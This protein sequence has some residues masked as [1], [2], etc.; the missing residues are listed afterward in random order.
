MISDEPFPGYNLVIEGVEP[1]SAPER[2]R[3]T[4][5]TPSRQ[6]EYNRRA[7]RSKI[8]RDFS[9]QRLPPWMQIGFMETDSLNRISHYMGDRLLAVRDEEG[10][11]QMA[12]ADMEMGA[13]RFVDSG[14]LP[15]ISK[16]IRDSFEALNG[17]IRTL[18]GEEEPPGWPETLT[19]PHPQEIPIE[20]H[21]M[22]YE[23]ERSLTLYHVRQISD[24]LPEL[25]DWPNTTVETISIGDFDT[26]AQT[27]F[28]PLREGGAWDI[29]T[30]LKVPPDE[31]LSH[32]LLVRQGA[33]EYSLTSRQ[34]KGHPMSVLLD[35]HYPDVLL[36]YI[37]WMFVHRA[38]K[39]IAHIK[40]PLSSI[41]KTLIFEALG[42]ATGLVA[43]YAITDLTARSQFATFEADLGRHLIVVL[44]E[45]EKS[46]KDIRFGYLNEMTAARV[47]INKKFGDLYRTARTAT[48]VFVGG[49]WAKINMNDQGMDT[50]TPFA[51]D[52]PWGR[53]STDA[54]YDDDSAG[55][56][57]TSTYKHIEGCVTCHEAVFTE[58]MNRASRL[59]REMVEQGIDEVIARF[60]RHPQVQASLDRLTSDRPSDIGA[61]LCEE[62][63]IADGE[64][65]V[66]AHL[67]NAIK[68]ASA[69]LKKTVSPSDQD[70]SRMMYTFFDSQRTRKSINR[71]QQWVWPNVKWVKE[72]IYE[73]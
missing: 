62:I 23:R 1:E 39:A 59:Y 57:P 48:P 52:T 53:E 47:T 38:G 12:V 63:E 49:D 65:I 13:W 50:R 25:S 41:G 29:A 55:R 40:H 5:V 7:A 4:T 64:F 6:T 32:H 58:L 14:T 31:Y 73:G 37:A 22:V 11:V 33:V 18:M 51:L 28:V 3:P 68:T 26:L 66:G 21:E 10:G 2:G 9:A 44:D 16:L 45:A 46:E 61:W 43:V 20:Y 54:A 36:D 30:G 27:T 19:L 70:I 71:K 56:I 24:R 17:D 42:W 35:K 34:A 69:K 15:L 72:G 8:A 67:R 60:R